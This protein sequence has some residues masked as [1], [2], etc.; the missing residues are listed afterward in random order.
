MDVERM[1]QG[2]ARDPADATAW[3]ALADALEEQGEGD[4]AELVRLGVKLREPIGGRKGRPAAERRLRELL[5]AGVTPCVPEV[6]VPGVGL[7]LCLVPPGS[8][9][10]GSP[11]GARQV[12]EWERPA[13]PVTL[14]RGFW[15]GVHPVTQAQWQAV[16]GPL[17][18]HC[19]FEGDDLPVHGVA[20]KSARH[21]CE[22]LTRKTG[23]RF[24]LPSEAEWEY[25]CRAGTST[26][27]CCGDGQEL[28]GE[29]AWYA[30]NAGDKPHPVGQKRPNAWGIHE[31]QGGIVE[32]CADWFGEYPDQPRTDPTGPAD[33]QMRVLRGAAWYCYAAHCR[34]AS[35]A[36][37]TPDDAYEGYGFRVV[38][39]L[40]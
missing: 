16:L 5:A 9:R 40:D 21:F 10:M 25:A 20:W 34:S 35:R 15:L 13:H 12:S 8:F 31:M 37:N 2:V 23:Q 6:V 7:K 26:A 36:R 18:P 11:A 32:W 1:L 29:H 14:T 33:G 22:K 30:D 28:L 17:P 4:R 24:R 3:L 38:R 39:E 27:Y 19:N